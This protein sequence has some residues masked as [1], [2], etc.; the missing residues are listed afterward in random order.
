MQLSWKFDIFLAHNSQFQFISNKNRVKI[1]AKH[2]AR[3]MHCLARSCSTSCKILSWIEFFSTL[4]NLRFWSKHWAPNYLVFE[5]Y[6]Q[7]AG[8][9]RNYVSTLIPNVSITTIQNVT[10]FKQIFTHV[11]TFCFWDIE[12]LIT[13]IRCWKW[14]PF[15]SIH[16]CNVFR[17][18]NRL[19]HETPDK[20]SE[21]SS[22]NDDRNMN[23]VPNENT[24]RGLFNSS[25]PNLLSAAVMQKISK[26]TTKRPVDCHIEN[27][28]NPENSSKIQPSVSFLPQPIST[29]Q[30]TAENGGYCSLRGNDT[31]QGCNI[32]SESFTTMTSNNAQY[33][34]KAFQ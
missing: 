25:N 34:N 4:M 16:S 18:L 3:I 30:E 24:T 17:L 10:N 23:M 22:A 2:S 19:V 31:T 15:W 20:N 12:S 11:R 27:Y 33:A 21:N 14:L 7:T 32:V 28:K 13:C 9:F 5:C 8:S 6:H 26:N 1:L 29:S